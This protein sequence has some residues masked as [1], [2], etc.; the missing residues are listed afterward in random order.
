MATAQAIND[1]LQQ[2]EVLFHQGQ[3]PA[4]S[5]LLSDGPAGGHCFAALRG[6]D[7]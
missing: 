3:F 2:T 4:A 7:L 1:I 5:Q 6:G